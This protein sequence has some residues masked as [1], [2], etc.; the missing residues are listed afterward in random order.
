MFQ[1]CFGKKKNSDPQARLDDTFCAYN[2]HIFIEKLKRH[3][4]SD[5][6]VEELVLFKCFV[7]SSSS[8]DRR[9]MMPR[10]K[11]ELVNAEKRILWE[12]IFDTV[13]P[14]NMD[15]NNN[16]NYNISFDQERTEDHPTNSI[17]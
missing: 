8:S 15:N 5:V 11:R 3:H 16:N 1:A 12:S 7:E 4:V 6:T 17:A 9:S 10:N 14:S 13:F 2:L